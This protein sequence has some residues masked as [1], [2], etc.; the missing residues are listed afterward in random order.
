MHPSKYLHIGGDETYLLGHCRHCRG[1]AQ[2]DGQS[3]LYVDYFKEIAQW[4]VKLGR[5]PL[6]WADMLLK[7]PEAVDE[8]PKECIFVDWNYGW[9]P[10]HFGDI[11]KIG[12]N[13]FE[14][15]GAAALRAHPDN[16]SLTNWEKHFNNLSYFIPQARSLQYTGM[17]ITSWSTS[18]V[19]G[20]EWDQ[21]GEVV[22]MYPM[23]RVYPLAGFKILLAAYAQSLR[24]NTPIVPREFVKDYAVERFGLAPRDGG[25][26]WRALTLDATPI[27]PQVDVV[28]IHEKAEKA[29][30]LM[31][32]LRP[33][34]HLSEFEHL[35][36]MVD[37]REFH[38]RFKKLEC[39]IQS[40]EFTSTQIPVKI[41]ALERLLGESETLDRRFIKANRGS[42]YG[43]ALAE[44]IEARSKKL[45]R[46]YD[47][48]T[49][50][51]RASRKVTVALL[52]LQRRWSWLNGSKRP[53][54]KSARWLPQ[55][56]SPQ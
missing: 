4:V 3:K 56:L 22:E 24:Q 50:S 29:K 33:R 37:L 10:K 55:P 1:K 18:G 47:R 13:G 16:H 43:K 9:Q 14:I 19:Y 53:L 11:T 7:H 48:L 12:R 32:S 52:G 44:E 42:L 54:P 51:G 2:R 5:R 30:R 39:E 49:R 38:V 45:Q 41:R 40:G 20:F 26:L 8:M 25:K 46:L 17:F 27:Q 15:W 6:L 21:G 23:R 36:L 28:T 31:A 35:R 34:R